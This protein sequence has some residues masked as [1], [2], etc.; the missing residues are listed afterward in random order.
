MLNKRRIEFMKFME[1]NT[2]NF[3]KAGFVGISKTRAFQISGLLSPRIKSF[4]S[5]SEKL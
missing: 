3:K 2:E 5:P 1:V 4:N